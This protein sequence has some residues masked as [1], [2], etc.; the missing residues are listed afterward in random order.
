VLRKAFVGP[1]GL[2]AGWKVLLFFL[3]V[4]AVGFC[5]RPVG[6]LSG[7]IDPKLPVPPG[8]ML[9]REFLRAITVLVATGIMARFIDRKPWGYFGIPIRDAF[10][11]AFWIGAAIG[12]SI[13]ALQ[14]EIMHLFGW[15]DFGTVQL[16]GGSIVAYGML[17]AL[18]FLCVGISE[19]GVL[20]GYVQRVTTD[21]LSMLPGTS[22]FW[23]SAVLFSIIFAAAHLANP[24]E[25][26]FGII[27][28][29]IDGMAMCF[30][31]WR[32]GD[33]WF[34]IGN[35]AAWDWGQT[36]VF[37]TPNSGVHAQHVLLNPT[38]HGP[39]LLAGGTDG[40]EGSV[41]VLL[42]EALIVV[43]VAIIYRTRKFPLITDRAVGGSG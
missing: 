1:H 17:W 31:L 37:G 41:L 28:V 15:F 6:K 14:L 33:L 36:F 23:T 18:M 26:K 21:G 32:T 12:L 9:F 13:L 38:F 10:R 16:N 34:A 40:P 29:F 30:S 20:R 27:M 22:S 7:K 3:I 43:L 4:F 19:E 35:H 39:T 2:R 8:P 25:N 11:S 5:L 24:D 42:S